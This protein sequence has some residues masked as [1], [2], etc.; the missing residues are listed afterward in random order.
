MEF[1]DEDLVRLTKTLWSSMLQLE[2][3]EMK[4]PLPVKPHQGR[5]TGSV[6][7]TGAWAGAVTVECSATLAQRAT[8]IMFGL[9]DEP[10]TP[11]LIRDAVGELVN[12]AGGNIKDLVSGACQLSLPTVMEGID[13]HISIPGSQCIKEMKFHC[14]SEPIIVCIL[15]REGQSM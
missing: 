3:E 9:E 8:T 12:I 13:Y 10:P 11:E 2:V 7:I 6:H 4:E 15:E 1:K 14:D 5:V